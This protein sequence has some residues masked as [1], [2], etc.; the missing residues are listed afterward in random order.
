MAGPVLPNGP[1]DRAAGLDRLSRERFDVVVIGAGVTGC[2][3]ALDAAARGLNVALVDA[4]DIASGTSSMSSKLVHGGLRYLSSKEYRLVAEALAE[5]QRLLVNAPH[6]VTPLPFL[7]PLFAKPGQRS[8]AA[9]KGMAKA[10][11]SALW[12]YD[13]VGGLRIGH[14]HSRVPAATA[15]EH[16]PS[17][18]TDRLVDS[19]LYWDA[20]ADD[21]RLALTLARSAAATGA[22]VATYAPVAALTSSGATA[23]GGRIDGARLADGTTI[24]AGVVVNAGGVWSE[25]VARLSPSSG[26]HVAIRPAKGVH[27]T[28]RSERLPCDYA[29]VLPVP[30]DR[31]SVFV[32][33]WP[34]TGFTYVGTTDT[35]YDGDLSSPRATADDVSYL[36]AAVNAWTTSDLTPADVTGTWAGL[37]PLVA[38]G[39]G[40]TADL[41]RRHTVDTS[42]EGLVTVTG[43][44]LTTYRRMAADAVDA[45]AGVL[46]RY[47]GRSPT[48]RLRLWGADGCEALGDPGAAA[49]LGIDDATLSHL[50][51]RFGGQARAVAALA[52]S[53]PGLAAPLVE[54]L[55]YLR[56]EAVHSA[57]HEMVHT[58]TDLLWRRTRA[59]IL[60]L[61]A[62][63][64]A[65]PGAA[66]L[67]GEVL[68]WSAGQRSA[69]VAEVRAAAAAEL[70][71]RS[72]PPAGNHQ[73]GDG[74]S[75]QPVPDRAPNRPVA[76]GR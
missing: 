49:R 40:A 12:L 33:P 6:L 32:V 14:R 1:F 59:G 72:G 58:L 11:S 60:D 26:D 25:Q 39:E 10:Y 20:R 50:I 15:L 63:V 16:L 21:A 38:G 7:I 19:F 55:P 44:K 65:A 34:H 30:G 37:R 62:T 35:D 47:V 73:P 52:A 18:R 67:V 69:E 41:S 76:T 74:A 5:R 42:P 43:G 23:Q 13:L 28:V 54:G 75:K 17:L 64:A 46:G 53:D 24:A 45:A 66:D 3:V 61:E 8:Q 68:G 36:L 9:V 70:A 48:K 31:R 71:A 27:L 22:V 4:G 2:G 56:A 51:G 57:R 29:T